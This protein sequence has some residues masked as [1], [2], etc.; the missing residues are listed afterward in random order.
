MVIQ[1]VRVDQVLLQVGVELEHPLGDRG[2]PQPGDELERPGGRLHHPGGQPVA[3]GAGDHGRV[4][5]VAQPQAV[6]G[7]QPGRERVV[8]H[9]QLLAGFVDTTVGDHPG[10]QQGG[11]DP[12]R[13][14]GGGLAGE[15]QAEHLLGSHGTGADQPDHPG[16]HHRGLAGARAGDDHPR[17]QRSGDGV[18]LL[19]GEPDAERLDQVVGVPEAGGRRRQV[20]HVKGH[21]TTCRPA[22]WAGQ[23]PRNG[24]YRQAGPSRASCCSERMIRAA[25]ASRPCTQVGGG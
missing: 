4:G 14:L 8:G 17:L 9:D 21:A 22:G 23:L 25:S 20:Q 19:I 11:A 7:D 10:Q 15:G 1:L 2:R 13:Q 6:L 3:R 12:V 18:Q 16:R 5:L 24:Q